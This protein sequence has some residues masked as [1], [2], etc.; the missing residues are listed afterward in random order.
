MGETITIEEPRDAVVFRKHLG[1]YHVR[2]GEERVVCVV[3]SK[4]RKELIIGV[5]GPD[6]LRREIIGVKQLNEDP[7]AVGDCVRFRRAQAGDAEG[8][9][10][11][12][13]G[14]ITE[15][16]PRRSCLS[17][18]D[19]RGAG[20]LTM[21]ANVDQVM[22]VFAAAQPAPNGGSS[23]ATWYLPRRTRFPR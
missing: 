3:S 1:R 23:T 21:A 6:A 14:V 17:R 20:T 13:G 7:V 18:P 16:L 22:C 9:G 8:A 5:P 2:D 15:V 11:G 4:L 10:D 12:I 19:P